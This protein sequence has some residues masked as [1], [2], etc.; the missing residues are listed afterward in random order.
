MLLVMLLVVMI[1]DDADGDV[2]LLMMMMNDPAAAAGEFIRLRL[3]L[4]ADNMRAYL[5]QCRQ[6]LGNRLIQ[7]V[8]MNGDTINPSKWWMLFAKKNF[9]STKHSIIIIIIHVITFTSSF[10]ILTVVLVSFLSASPQ[11]ISYRSFTASLIPSK[12]F[13]FVF[14][15]LTLS[16]MTLK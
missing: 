11:S 16:D 13:Y 12:F 15:S 6:E 10:T 9:L 5:T 2:L 7:R 1:C 4:T 8:Y 14:P 3:F